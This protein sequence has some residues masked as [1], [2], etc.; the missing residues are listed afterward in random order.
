M[1]KIA[2]EPDWRIHGTRTS[3]KKEAWMLQLCVFPTILVN[4]MIFSRE[5]PIGQ[6]SVTQLKIQNADHPIQ[7]QIS[8]R[9][10]YFFIFLSYT[11]GIVA[12]PSIM[13]FRF[14]D[15]KCCLGM[16]EESALETFSVD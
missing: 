12:Q 16:N 11:F 3:T 4:I 6:K 2:E 15:Y 1:S 7:C 10:G 14:L 9:V 13:I 5:A 8:D